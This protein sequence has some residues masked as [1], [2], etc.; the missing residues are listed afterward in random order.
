MNYRTPL[1]AVSLATACGE[2]LAAEYG[3]VIASTPVVEQVALPQQY[4]GDMT[5]TARPAT[6]GAG[7]LAGALVGGVV[8]NGIGGGAGRGAAAGLGAVAGAILG[9]RAEAAN[10]AVAETTNRSCQTVTKY[11]S[12]VIG[13]DVT[14][15][16]R[17]QR[18][19]ARFAQAPGARVALDVSAS[20]AG[21]VVAP[22]VASTLAAP[23]PTDVS[24]IYVPPPGFG[25]YGPYPYYGYYGYE[26]YGGPIVSVHPRF[27]FGGGRRRVF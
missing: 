18:Y 19:S 5:Q 4:C 14:Y 2:A 22:A 11:E 26:G 10:S 12:R 21:G 8:G 1:I 7:A 20:P 25:L 17:G 6:T 15:D 27:E 9:D 3:D 16:Y 23:S 24:P 13:Y